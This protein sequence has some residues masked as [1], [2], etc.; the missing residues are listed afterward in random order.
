MNKIVTDEKKIEE[1]LTRGVEN[2]FPN[3]KALKKELMSGK[4]LRLYCGFDPS[5]DSLHI[6]NAIQVNKMS[7]FQE[8]GHKV[9]FLVGDFTGMIGDPT[10][11]AAARKKLNRKEVLENSKH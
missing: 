7:Q 8:L 9:I 5:A 11:K 4:R 6:G 10:D 2:I 1:V 3:K